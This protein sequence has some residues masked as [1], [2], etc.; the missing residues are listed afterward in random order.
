MNEERQEIRV[1]QT[2]AELQ[3]LFGDKELAKRALAG[4]MNPDDELI[5]AAKAKRTAAPTVL[6]DLPLG[7]KFFETS[8]KLTPHQVKTRKRNRARNLI[9]KA[10]RRAQRSR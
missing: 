5:H 1:D 7:E 9:A 10:T 2:E 8:V 6:T 4:R 3:A